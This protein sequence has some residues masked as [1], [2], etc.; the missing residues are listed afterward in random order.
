[1]I[2]RVEP[3]LLDELPP[4][5]PQARR[6]REDLR[7]LNLLMGHARIVARAFI[8]SNGGDKP[9][10]L[11]EIGAGDGRFA[12]SL[13]RRLSPRWPNLEVVL[14]DRQDIV[15]QQTRRAFGELGWN[16]DAVQADV[17]D[18]LKGSHRWP[19][20]CIVANLFLHHFTDV[21]LR[22]LLALVAERAKCF[23][24]CEPRRYRPVL[25]A[26]RLLG[27]IGCSEVTHHDAAVS[28]RAGFRG[29]ELSGSW[30]ANA[31]WSFE[32]GATGLFSHR[33][34]ARAWMGPER[35]AES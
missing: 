8:N 10:R 14:V 34:V 7:R 24:A 27:W 25:A 19:G 29:K 2:R 13:A 15:E 28:V 30:P 20:D 3:E 26:S 11:V 17:F 35:E 18:W 32:E 16:C 31:G 23:V 9:K 12:L 5:D 4:G 22:E 1:M 6:S 33:F 21:R